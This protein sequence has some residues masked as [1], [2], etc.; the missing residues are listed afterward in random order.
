MNRFARWRPSPATII[1]LV[2]LFVALGGTSYAALS[3]PRNSVNSASVVNGSLQK[4]DLSENAVNLLKG[5][6]GPRGPQGSQGGLGPQG[7][8]GATGTQ[9]PKGDSGAQGAMGQQGPKGDAGA[10]GAQGLKGDKGDPGTPAT[11][12]WARVA[13]NGTREAGSTGVTSTRNL[14]GIYTVTFPQDVSS[15]AWTA[16][17]RNTIEVLATPDSNDVANDSVRVLVRDV[18]TSHVGYIDAY[19]S[20]AVFC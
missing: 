7:P 10:Q 5:N 2:A 20:L 12:L 15:C 13:F 17:V 1:S 19:F 16:S 4:V 6:R 9:G 11:R 14:K 3:I 8:Q 18:G